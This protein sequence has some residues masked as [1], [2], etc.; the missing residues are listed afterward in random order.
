MAAACAAAAESPAGG[1]GYAGSFSI[2]RSV[3]RP[4]SPAHVGRFYDVLLCREFVALPPE[5]KRWLRERLS[6]FGIISR[7][8]SLTSRTFHFGKNC[9]QHK[10]QQENN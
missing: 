4:G 1:A 9:A 10:H 2:G 8:K 3:F 7:T 6:V 5:E